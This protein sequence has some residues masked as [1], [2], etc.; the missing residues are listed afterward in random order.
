MKKKSLAC[1]MAL[2][3]TLAYAG[4]SVNTRTFP[5]FPTLPS[6]GC[7]QALFQTGAYWSHQG[8]AQH[9]NI[10]SLIG[11]DFSVTRHGNVN[12]F[13]GFG[14]LFDGPQYR[15]LQLNYGV[16][17]FYLP[18]TS[19]FGY[20]LQEELFTNLSYGYY[21]THFPV[22]AALEATTDL[23]RM[24]MPF[25]SK[26]PGKLTVDVG[27]GPNFMK[28]A[29]F[30]EHSIDGGIT[31]PDDAF[32][33]RSTTT[34]TVTAGASVIVPNVFGAMSLE[35]GYR[36]FYLGDSHLRRVNDQILNALKTGDIYANAV[37][38]GVRI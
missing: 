31:I 23:S 37:V 3:C 21:V 24:P 10:E 11:D 17:A 30:I 25:L 9:V 8:Q 18:K 34:F 13:F 1:L 27:I 15:G 32:G 5:S 29:G 14:Y 16:H 2:G 12:S 28:T 35:C 33:N 22:Y 36:F 26:L 20:V 19:V 7:G 6:L 4:P 38:V